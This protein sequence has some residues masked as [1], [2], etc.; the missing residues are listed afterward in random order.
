MQTAVS[1]NLKTDQTCC[2][3]IDWHFPI[4]GLEF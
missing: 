2:I 1:E 4:I 3:A